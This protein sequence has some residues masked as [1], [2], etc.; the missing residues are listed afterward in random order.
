MTKQK[1]EGVLMTGK[2]HMLDREENRETV[3]DRVGKHE[4]EAKN[5]KG[6]EEN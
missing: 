6:V 1:R 3:Q 5:K 2:G 4:R